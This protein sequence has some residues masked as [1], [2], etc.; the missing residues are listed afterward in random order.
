[1]F[2][3]EIAVASTAAHDSTQKYNND[4]FPQ[5]AAAQE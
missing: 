1:M 5:C 3:N 4:E 2:S